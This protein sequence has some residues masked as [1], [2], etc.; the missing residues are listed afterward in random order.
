MACT[1]VIIL[2]TKSR[3][4]ADE[5]LR[6][7]KRLNREGWIDLTCYALRR[8][9]RKERAARSRDQREGGDDRTGGCRRG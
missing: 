3:D 5:A 2:F 8:C 6:E 1:E 9:G 4:A 7:L